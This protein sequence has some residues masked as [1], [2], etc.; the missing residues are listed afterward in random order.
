LNDPQTAS[1]HFDEGLRI[2]TNLKQPLGV[3][4]SK[5]AIG[6]LR[7]AR[8]DVAGACREIGEARDI[9]AAAG[10]GSGVYLE[11][12]DRLRGSLCAGPPAPDAVIRGWE[13][14][15]P[16]DLWDLTVPQTIVNPDAAVEAPLALPV[17]DQAPAPGN[18]P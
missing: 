10:A 16:Y 4:G 15:N 17:G 14:L 7:G 6:V 13:D 2:Y 1:M 9:F 3:A 5:L 11:Q 18:H 8:N 12:I